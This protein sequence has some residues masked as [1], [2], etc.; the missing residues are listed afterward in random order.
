MSTTKHPRA[1]GLIRVSRMSRRRDSAHSPEVQRRLIEPFADRQAWDLAELLNENEIRG[2]DVSGGA[3]PRKRPGFGP[4]IDAVEAGDADVIVAADLSRLFRDIDEQRRTIDAIEAVGGE[5]WTVADGRVTHETAQA[6]LTANINGSMN[7]FQRR[8]AKEKSWLAVEIAIEQGK[9]PW[10]Q[11]AP[12]Y[13]REDSRL[14]PDAGL[15]PVIVGAFEL[16]DSGAPVQAVQA[17]LAERGIK[18]SFHGTGHLLRDRIYVGEIHF[19]Q[20]TPNLQAHAPIVDRA[21]FD[22]VQ[23]KKISR[24]RRAKSERLLA[25]L[26]VLRCASCDA[27]M[28]VGT[29]NHSRYFIYRCPPVVACEHHPTIAA[30]LIEDAVV[31]AVRAALADFDGQAEAEARGRDARAALVAAQEA[32]EAATRVVLGAGLGSEPLAVERLSALR[33]ERDDASA[34][35]DR[36]GFSDASLRLNGAED[37]D[38][39]SLD[40]RRALILAVVRRVTVGPGRGLDRVSVETFVKESPGG[41]VEDPFYGGLVGFR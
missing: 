23:A 36:I 18:R 19:G 24:G 25:R 20:H 28:V 38:S 37:W 11:T 40:G 30:T 1:L 39:L 31:E 21:L 27:R 10:S 17:F 12:G 5:F 2:G 9:V 6:E 35:V 8:Y 14:L 15:V 3:D 4:A 13:V 29:G 22:R 32:L 41:G 34:A 16:R 7:H 26:G 33:Q